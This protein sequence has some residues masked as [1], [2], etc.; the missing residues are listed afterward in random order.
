VAVPEEFAQY[1]GRVVFSPFSPVDPEEVNALESELEQAIPTAHR[2][3]LEVANGGTL[4]YSVRVPPGPQGEPVSFPELYRL[5]RDQHGGYGWGTLLGEYRWLQPTWLGQHLPAATLLPIART[6]GEEDRAFLDLSPT[7]TAGHWLRLRP[8]AVD[9]AGDPATCHGCWPTT[10][11][12]T[13]TA[14]SSILT[15]QSSSSGSTRT[16]PAG[17]AD[18]GAA[19]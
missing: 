16:C 3:F 14:R 18:P 4:P 6:G 11:T 2:S 12:P 10:S 9:H 15:M 5:G 13:W 1:R 7:G 8:A 17:G 19:R